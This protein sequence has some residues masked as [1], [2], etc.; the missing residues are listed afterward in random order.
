ATA[1]KIATLLSFSINNDG[2]SLNKIHFPYYVD[3]NYK[4][5]CNN[6]YYNFIEKIPNVD[7]QKDLFYL[8]LRMV[9]GNISLRSAK[10]KLFK[11][12]MCQQLEKDIEE[13]ATI[14]PEINERYDL[15]FFKLY[16]DKLQSVK[17][18]I[19]NSSD[20]PD[21]LKLNYYIK[22][23]YKEVLNRNE[24]KAA[25]FLSDK[26]SKKSWGENVGSIGLVIVGLALVVSSFI[27]MASYPFAI[28]T[29]PGLISGVGMF[30]YGVKLAHYQPKEPSSMAKR[31]FRSYEVENEEFRESK[32]SSSLSMP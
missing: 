24:I 32:N 1:I 30:I 2:Y 21:L 16:F 18:K 6:D 28:Y 19:K 10:S 23:H 4:D 31:F 8:L 15:N 12:I 13:V 29:I 14:I 11:I 9:D 27:I 26:I 7:M 3:D 5:D 20:L 17:E 22:K 25:L